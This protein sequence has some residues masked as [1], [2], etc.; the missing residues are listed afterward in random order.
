MVRE[1]SGKA[2]PPDRAIRAA[3]KT[4]R[5]QADEIL[6]VRAE[7]LKQREKAVRRRQKK[8]PRLLDARVVSP[9]LQALIGPPST[10]VLVAEGDSWFDYPFH[11]VLGLLEDRY[12]YDIESVAHKGDRVEDMAYGGG[13]LEDF[14][15]R[16]E[17]VLR[18]NVVPKAILLSGGGN[19]VAGS[20]FAMLLNHILSP[21][22]GL[23]TQVLQ[24][25]VDERISLSYVTILEALA[26]MCEAHI[27]RPLPV[28]VHG[29]DYPVPDGRGFLGGWGILP[30]PWLEPGFRA[31]GYE[32]LQER[33]SLMRRLMDR[34]NAM[35]QGVTAL[36][37][38][39]HVHY[40]DLRNTLS[41]GRDY[42][43]DW[44]NELHPTR[45][46][47]QMVADRF[48]ETLQQL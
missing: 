27:G 35:L 23:N 3:R 47:F 5:R 14:L 11:D 22:P 2:S 30:G 18:R 15:R 33:I 17:K 16:I 28:L 24:G 1:S 20:G 21:S 13:Q 44:G 43:K 9:R 10:E 38:F 7:Q 39:Q 46:G 45:K 42:K 12:G 34:F 36:A 19:D 6:A 48:E 37:R 40:V 4:G 8:A 26:T 32:D 29:Y 41:S 25:V 31:K